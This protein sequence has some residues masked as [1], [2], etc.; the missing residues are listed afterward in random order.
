MELRKDRIKPRPWR[1]YFHLYSIL[2]EG[3]AAHLF[4]PTANKYSAEDKGG[5][6]SAGGEKSLQQD[7]PRIAVF[8]DRVDLL[9][10]ER[11]ETVR[12]SGFK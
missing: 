1:P 8:F 9:I 10:H 11:R 4:F 3:R 12:R 6:I 5:W 7:I 2:L